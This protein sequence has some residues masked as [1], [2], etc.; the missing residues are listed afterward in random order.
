MPP[1]DWSHRSS[2]C[3]G[4]KLTLSINDSEDTPQIHIRNQGPLAAKHSLTVLLRQG[5][6]ALG[7][8]HPLGHPPSSPCR[9]RRELP[10]KPVHHRPEWLSHKYPAHNTQKRARCQPG[11]KRWPCQS[12]K[13]KNGSQVKPHDSKISRIPNSFL[14]E[15]CRH[16]TLFL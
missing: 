9:E 3:G 1:K 14:V 15:K 11:V 5:G 2:E 12:P 13:K 6:A 10:S 7:S 16:I 8:W 4:S